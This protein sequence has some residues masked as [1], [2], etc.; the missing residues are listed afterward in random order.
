MHT[1]LSTR[2]SVDS[3]GVEA[4]GSSDTPLIS[5]NGRFVTFTSSASNL[6]PNDDNNAADVFVHD[7]NTGATTLLTKKANGHSAAGGFLAQP[8]GISDD[9]SKVLFLSNS[10]DL[11]GGSSAVQAYL[12]DTG[13]GTITMVSELSTC[14]Y[15]NAS[16]SRAVMTPDASRIAYGIFC[17]GSG[18]PGVEPDSTRLVVRD[19]RAHTTSTVFT[20]D[21]INNATDSYEVEPKSVTASGDIM[22]FILYDQFG[23]HGTNTTG[24]VRQNGTN[25]VF[26]P[27][28]GAL[29]LG[30]LVV[31]PNGRFL[32]YSVP[33]SDPYA[34]QNTNIVLVDTQ[35]GKRYWVAV[36]AHDTSSPSG[37]SQDEVWS[38]DGGTIAFD[39]NAEDINRGGPAETGYWNVYTRPLHAVLEFSPR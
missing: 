8:Q 11:G 26:D 27:Q 36:T 33:L 28:E 9:G 2:V 34:P 19:F 31:S 10:P 3:N 30:S 17:S 12:V 14:P 5:A 20:K 18:G 29:T 38:R 23:V 24:Y 15:P 25:Q 35:T 6:A 16:V 22:T 1:G 32:L 37:V 39:S 13:T 21:T 4:N 7:M